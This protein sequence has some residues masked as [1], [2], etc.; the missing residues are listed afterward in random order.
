MTSLP[1]TILIP[2]GSSESSCGY[3][4]SPGERSE[5]DTSVSV[6]ASARQMSCQIY[7]DMINMGWRRS[8]TYNYRPLLEE[9]CCPQYPIRLDA[10]AFDP[11]RNQRKA[12]YRFNRFI[13]EGEAD[14]PQGVDPE[15]TGITAVSEKT[16][17]AK[18]PVKVKPRKQVFSLVDSI[19]EPEASFRSPDDPSPKYRL[20]IT[21]EMAFYTVEKFELFKDYQFHVH[22]ETDKTSYGFKRF[23]CDTCLVPTPIPYSGKPP[24]SLPTM[25]GTYHQLYRIDGE[26][27][28][29]SVIDILPNC[30]SG[31]YFVYGH[32]WEKCQL[33]KL[34]VLR[35]AALA[36]EFYAAGLK[37]LKWVYLGFYIHSCQKMRYKG[38]YSPSYLLDT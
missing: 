23:L 13:I 7:Q 37:E 10:L 11:T 19:H 30:V 15:A 33:G 5:D 35:E 18:K 29:M 38:D 2:H 22:K 31:V 32:K 21:L 8:G 9:T 25:Y 4:G 6:G 12:L 16:P 34:S 17:N 28:A 36:R 26:L 1:P 14:G 24:N 20:E 3:C 27:A